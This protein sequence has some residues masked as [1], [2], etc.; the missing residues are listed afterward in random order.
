MAL[1]LLPTEL[2]FDAEE[3]PFAF[4]WLLQIWLKHKREQ[5][6]TRL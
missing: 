1:F 5:L 4:Y 3:N 6:L 2:P